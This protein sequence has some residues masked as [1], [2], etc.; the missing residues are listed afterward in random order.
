MVDLIYMALIAGFFL[1]AIAYLIA[2]DACER[3]RRQMSWES[4][5]ASVCAVLLLV[6]LV[7][8]LLRAER[9]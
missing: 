6:Y 2:C 9:F 5:L 3:R 1:I 7:Y 4:I 8:A